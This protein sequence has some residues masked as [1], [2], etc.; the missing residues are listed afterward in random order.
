M[1]N[2]TESAANE[3]VVRPKRSFLRILTVVVRILMGLPLFVGGL[4]GILKI[5]PEPK[6]QLPEAATAF[7]AALLNTGYMLPLIFCTQLIVGTLLLANRFVPLALTLF[8]PFIVNAVAFHLF[9]EPS[10]RIMA[11]LFLV[12]ELFLAWRYRS[13]F[14][15]VLSAKAQ[16]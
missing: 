16:H 1:S 15:G 12:M 10:G 6:P 4:N 5:F 7:I 13:A 11:D 8:A 9:L 2:G 3:N 14:K